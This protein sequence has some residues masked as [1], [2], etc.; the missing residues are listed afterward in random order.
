MYG[1]RLSGPDAGFEFPLQRAFTNAANALA[2]RVAS[3]IPQ[4]TGTKLS[5][6]VDQD[7]DYTPV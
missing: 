7:Y 1:L 6:I 2:A 3:S 4:E 5:S